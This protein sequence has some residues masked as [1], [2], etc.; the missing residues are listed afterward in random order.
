[1]RNK[2]IPAVYIFF[3]KNNQILLLR[4]E[5]SGYMDGFYSLV[6]GHV[7]EN[8]LPTQCCI[9]EA[10]EE[11][12]IKIKISDLK[13]VLIVHRTLKTDRVDYF[14][15]C[16]KWSG[17]IKINE[18]NKCSDLRWFDLNNLPDKVMPYLLK[19]IEKY[20]QNINFMELEDE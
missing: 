9:R 20:K 10:L 19:V 18:P 17:I 8:E 4:R 3:R 7:E 6:A 16:K 12:N 2:V 1:M 13:F 11:A 14:F 5:N 15:E